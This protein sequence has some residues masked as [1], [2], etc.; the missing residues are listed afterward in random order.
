MFQIIKKFKSKIAL[1]DEY[2]GKISYQDL[3]IKEGG[4]ASR[5]FGNMLKGEFNGD[6]INTREQLLKYCQ[7]DTWAMVKILDEIYFQ[8]AG[9]S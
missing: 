1:I 8:I 6:E 2:K 5:I 4:T 3:E 7:R 9:K